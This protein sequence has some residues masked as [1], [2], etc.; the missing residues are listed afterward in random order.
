M[1]AVPRHRRAGSTKVFAQATSSRKRH[2]A[3]VPRAAARA[4]R[5]SLA[6]HA[7]LGGRTVRI[8]GSVASANCSRSPNQGRARRQR[9]L[10]SSNTASRRNFESA[11]TPLQTRY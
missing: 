5:I 10:I 1:E 3:P 11:L 8:R 6:K 9:S 2:V 7:V 4:Q